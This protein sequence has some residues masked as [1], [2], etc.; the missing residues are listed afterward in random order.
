[1]PDF[2]NLDSPHQY[3]SFEEFHNLVSKFQQ[4]LT[5]EGMRR[6]DRVVILSPLSAD[7]YALVIAMGSLNIVP[8]FI[9]RTL[10]FFKF[11]ELLKHS[12]VVSIVSTPGFHRLRWILPQLRSYRLYSLGC[13]GLGF[14]NLKEKFP[15]LEPRRISTIALREETPALITYTTGS[16]G[17]PKGADRSHGVLFYQYLLSQKY[18]PE[19]PDEVDMPWFPMVAF[20]NFNC[21]IRTVLP[22]TNFKCIDDFD[23]NFVIQQILSE[24]VTRMSAPPSVYFRL[25]NDL[26]DRGLFLPQLRRL[27]VGGAPVSQKLARLIRKAFP[28]AEVHIVYGSTEVE[29]ISFVNL[30]DWIKASPE[31]YLVGRPIPEV[32]VKVCKDLEVDPVEGQGL[33]SFLTKGVGEILV[34]GPHVVKRYFGSD[35]VNRATK[36]LDSQRRVW[37]RTGDLGYQDEQG[38]LW[39]LG[40]LNDGPCYG[41]EHQIELLEGVHRAAFDRRGR[42]HVQWEGERLDLNELKTQIRSKI[43]MGSFAPPYPGKNFDEVEIKFKREMPLDHRHRWK[44][45]RSKL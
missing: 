38:R 20:Q 15:D 16:T 40:R 22:G 1:M 12:G 17:Q 6:A 29:P 9:D 32:Q 44:I 34:H 39:I 43:S 5:Q 7:L 10:G 24:G 31:A 33:E 41:V 36:I 23:S 37:H 35:E 14:K 4:V 30:D 19:D 21:G 28:S 25:C 11:L 2:G 26:L 45:N 27:I 13:S 42:L 8:V 18:W 3:F